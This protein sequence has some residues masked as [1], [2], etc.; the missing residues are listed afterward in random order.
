VIWRHPIAWLGLAALAVPILVHLL[1]RAAARRQRFP[2]LRFLLASRQMPVRRDRLKDLGL[3]AIRCGVVVAATAALAQP[4]SWSANR[5]QAGDAIARAILVDTSASMAR[6]APGGGSALDTARREAGR[7]AASSDGSRIV[8]TDAPRGDLEGA[9]AWLATQPGRREVAVLSD[10]QITA[11]DEADLRG[12]PA[13]TGVRLVRVEAGAWPGRSP[14]PAVL[15]LSGPGERTRADA[16][17]HAARALRAPAAARADRPVAV[18]FQDAEDYR[19]LVSQA[20]PFDA[21]WMFDVS[22]AV[23]RDPLLVEAAAGV[24]AAGPPASEASASAAIVPL[25]RTSSGQPAVLAAGGR[26]RGEDRLLF[27]PLADAGSPLSAALVA[28]VA[29]ATGDAPTARELD[30]RTRADRELRTWERE[31][32]PP[33]PGPGS[34]GDQSDG[35]WLWGVAL[36]L[37]AVEAWGR[38]G[39][40]AP[41]AEAGTS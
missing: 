11:L 36:L 8:M 19:A 16:A 10:F 3:L 30:A 38:R 39:R 25:V 15:I 40:H 41:A 21:A 9:L 27:F 32:A 17:W 37:L 29:R 4:L 6:A 20:T 24:E 13:G 7:L 1:G 26:V 23:A 28:A 18:V 34:A 35:R 2:T 33:A 12:V 5:A 22:A 14:G 31:P